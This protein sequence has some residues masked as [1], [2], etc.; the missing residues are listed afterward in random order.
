MALCST[1]FTSG[2]R[3]NSFLEIINGCLSS[4]DINVCPECSECL[5]VCTDF[6]DGCNWVSSWNP[7]SAG[8]SVTTEA[9]S[10]RVEADLSLVDGRVFVFAE[11]EMSEHAYELVAADESA[12]E[13]DEADGEEGV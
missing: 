7:I 5:V 13:E 2:D 10:I 6:D 8:V 4:I 12:T 11:D 9:Y 1:L 3:S